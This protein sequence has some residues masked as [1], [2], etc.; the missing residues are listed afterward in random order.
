MQLSIIKSKSEQETIFSLSF[1]FFEVRYKNPKNM[2]TAPQEMLGIASTAL[3]AAQ[4]KFIRFAKILLNDFNTPSR[5]FEPPMFIA[6]VVGNVLPEAWVFCSP[7][8]AGNRKNAVIPI[9]SNEKTAVFP[10][11]KAKV[12]R[13]FQ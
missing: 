9:P 1:I 10:R 7:K 11:S 3:V 5:S 6:N 8:N 13:F 2:Q 4:V 12:L